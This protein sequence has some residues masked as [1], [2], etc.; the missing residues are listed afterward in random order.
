[1]GVPANNLPIAQLTDRSM[2]ASILH[3]LA[4]KVCP[5]DNRAAGTVRIHLLMPNEQTGKPHKTFVGENAGTATC[6]AHL[7]SNSQAGVPCPFSATTASFKS[8]R[9]IHFRNC[10]VEVS[11]ST[12]SSVVTS[13]EIVIRSRLTTIFS[14]GLASF[15]LMS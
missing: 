11:K 5:L 3:Y 2:N 9:P 7:A 6:G 1:M 12:R 10:R 4:K 8:F 14:A 15:T 13:L